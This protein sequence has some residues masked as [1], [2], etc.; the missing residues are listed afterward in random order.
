MSV[1]P[2]P[3]PASGLIFDPG[4]QRTRPTT[5][6][7]TAASMITIDFRPTFKSAKQYVPPVRSIVA[8]FWT[9]TKPYAPGG[10]V[11]EPPLRTVTGVVPTRHDGTG[12]SGPNNGIGSQPSGP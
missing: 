6:T 4:K 3:E 11:C 1:A 10:R 2:R 9:F 7:S 8:P 5:V 12:A